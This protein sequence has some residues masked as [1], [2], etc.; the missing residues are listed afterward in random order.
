M[1]GATIKVKECLSVYAQREF[2]V[3]VRSIRSGLLDL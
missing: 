2:G 3:N 1:H